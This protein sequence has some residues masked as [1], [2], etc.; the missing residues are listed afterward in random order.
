[1]SAIAD[2]REL[3]E[4]IRTNVPGKLRELPIWL[5][6]KL[7]TQPGEKSKKIPYYA[8]GGPRSKTETPE[9]RAQLTDFET[10]AAALLRTPRDGLGIAL[11]EVPGEDIHISG[12]DLDGIAVDSHVRMPLKKTRGFGGPKPQNR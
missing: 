11:G 1:M 7:V 4:R 6:W 10:A 8:G 9:D 5:V 12:I 3:I 2:R